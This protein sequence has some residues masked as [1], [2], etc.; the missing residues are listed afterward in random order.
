MS[1]NAKAVQPQASVWKVEDPP[2]AQ[3]LFS[4][5]KYSWIWLILRVYLGYEWLLAGWGKVQNPVW[6]GG[7]AGGAIA[8]FVKGALAKTAGEHPDV[9]VWYAWFLQHAVLPYAN[10]WSNAIAV[11]ELLVGL[12]LI[13]GLFTGIAAFF[14]SFMNLNYLFAGT[15]STN[16]LMLIIATWLVLGWKTAGWLGLDR[17]ALPMM[18]TPWR[19]GRVMK[20]NAPKS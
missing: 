13:V 12:G 4:D 20:P 7:T 2:A 19:P 18:G 10:A 16:P 1:T 5:V 11:G 17:W 6:F 9:P 3:A 15:V 14:G 8:G